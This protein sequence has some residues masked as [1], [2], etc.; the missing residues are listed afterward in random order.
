[1]NRSSK[2]ITLVLVGTTAALAGFGVL[3]RATN[4]AG[5]DS[6]QMSDF[7]TDEEGLVGGTQ[8]STRPGSCPAF[9]R[10]VA[11]LL[12]EPLPDVL[13]LGL[14]LVR[15]VRD[16]QPFVVVFRLLVIRLIE[17]SRLGDV[18]RRVRQQRARGVEQLV[19]G[20][21]T[22]QDAP[23]GLDC[24]LAYS[25]RANEQRR[26]TCAGGGRKDNWNQRR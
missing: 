23:I 6:A 14:S 4:P 11:R 7:G 3:H 20:N 10:D 25:G 15:L 12:V 19:T 13:V 21:R 17:Q 5:D 26:A 16:D 2:T 18:P 9:R 22:R 8:P 24:L 1:M